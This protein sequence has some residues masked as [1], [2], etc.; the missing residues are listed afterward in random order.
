MIRFLYSDAHVSLHKNIKVWFLPYCL[1]LVRDA[2]SWLNGS[3]TTFSLGFV[4]FQPF[5]TSD[6]RDDSFVRVSP[7]TYP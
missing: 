3:D 2:C 1:L 7:Q 5:V 6:E 4:I